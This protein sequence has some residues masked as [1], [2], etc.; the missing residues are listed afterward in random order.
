MPKENELALTYLAIGL[1]IGIMFMCYGG[2]QALCNRRN[3]RMRPEYMSTGFIAGGIRPGAPYGMNLLGNNRGFASRQNMGSDIFDPSE[4]FNPN[5]AVDP[6]LIDQW[7]DV[8][9]PGANMNNIF[10][11]PNVDEGIE[12]VVRMDNFT[13]YGKQAAEARA[14]YNRF[15]PSAS[16]SENFYPE[17]KEDFSPPERALNKKNLV[18]AMSDLGSGWESITYNDKNIAGVPDVVAAYSGAYQKAYN[19]VATTTNGDLVYEFYGLSKDD[20]RRKWNKAFPGY[21]YPKS[22]Q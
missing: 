14:P 3:A 13:A 17:M 20:A 19:L 7:T 16:N 10:I 8:S 21:E 22:I 6:N 4:G 9:L 12:S 18:E 5:V 1:V 11:D 2:Y 15:W